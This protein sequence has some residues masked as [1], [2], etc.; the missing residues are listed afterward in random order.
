VA[1]RKNLADAHSGK[2]PFFVRD[3]WRFLAPL[4]ICRVVRL[5]YWQ[6]LHRGVVALC[7]H[8]PV[9][10]FGVTTLGEATVPE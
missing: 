10:Q 7:Q 2:W 5:V 1:S 9:S 6:H 8:L 3:A 4:T